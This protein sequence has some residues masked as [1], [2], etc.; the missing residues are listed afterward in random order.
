MKYSIQNSIRTRRQRAGRL[1]LA[2]AAWLTAVMSA[3]AQHID[4]IAFTVGTTYSNLAGEEWAYIAWKINEPVLSPDRTFAVYEKYGGANSTHPYHRVSVVA[5]QTDPATLE[6]L[7]NRAENVGDFKDAIRDQ[8]DFLFEDLLAPGNTFTAG[9][10][11]SAIIRNAQTDETVYEHLQ[12]LGAAHPG[13]QLGLG[14]AYM[15]KIEPGSTATFEIREY[16]ERTQRDLRVIG[17][18]T[19]TAGNPLILPAPGTVFS[20]EE[21][22][23]KGHLNVQL[24]WATPDV[25]RQLSPLQFGFSLYRME[26]GFAIAKGLA[27][28][29]QLFLAPPEQP[30]CVGAKRYVRPG[31]SN[32]RR[33]D[34]VQSGV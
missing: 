22:S 17:R 20:P 13:I 2:G 18:V 34:L 3:P 23:G 10:K 24:R 32:W 12:F 29:D 26:A 16:D 6:A 4:D 15:K 31:G 27:T 7:L 5:L 14:N 30:A 28:N 8:I 21:T 11:L 33:G 25:L 19:M 9:E 1:M